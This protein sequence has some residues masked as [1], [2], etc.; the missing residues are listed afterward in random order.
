MP[1]IPPSAGRHEKLAIVALV[2][3]AL[4]WSGNF[5]AG[6][7]LRDDIDPVAL[8]LVRWTLCLLLLLT[9]ISTKLVRHRRVVLREWRLLLG[10][11]ASGIAAF[12]TLTYQ[13]L[14]DTMAVNALLI[15][16]LAPTAILAGAWLTGDSSPGAGIDPRAWASL[17]E[18]CG[19]ARP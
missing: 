12:H 18:R 6:R 5:I 13:A 2:A 10:L 19:C 15:L 17:A 11:G 3:A 7:A 4:F 16:A 14:S 1:G 8:N 9:L